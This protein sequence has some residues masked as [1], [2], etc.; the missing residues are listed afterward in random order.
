[1]FIDLPVHLLH[2]KY[3]NLVSTLFKPQPLKN[4]SGSIY[5]EISTIYYLL[6]DDHSTLAFYDHI[7]PEKFERCQC[8]AA[9]VISGA[10]V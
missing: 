7:S 5:Y 10:H 6:C 8:G 4:R 2:N 3:T 9:R 1:M